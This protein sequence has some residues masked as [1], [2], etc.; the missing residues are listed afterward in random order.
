MCICLVSVL[1][2]FGNY[3]SQQIL[4]ASNRFLPVCLKMTL[5][6]VIR[7]HFVIERHLLLFRHYIAKVD[8]LI[9]PQ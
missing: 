2:P 7:R 9:M 1:I 5:K 6:I 8:L 3:K 4:C